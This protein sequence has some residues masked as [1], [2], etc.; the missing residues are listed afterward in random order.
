[1]TP[2]SSTDGNGRA[3]DEGILDPLTTLYT[4]PLL[5]AVL[6]KSVGRAS[7]YG[8]SLSLILFDLDHFAAIN[9]AYGRRVGDRILERLGILVRG[10]FR[11]YDWVARHGEDSIAV[12]LAPS[13]G[14]TAS[15][16]AQQVC[17]T[18][19]ER[20]TFVDHG[21]EQ[22]VRVTISAAVVNVRGGQR[23]PLEPARVM[24]DADAALAR[25]K[26][27][28]RNRVERVDP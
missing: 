20:L 26:Q 16:L 21:T 10:Y 3:V 8:E 22:T 4:R 11:Q 9:E 28:G 18:V 19:A 5:D 17:T 6:A 7:R 1:V 13:E 25:A 15:E 24:A 23:E 14:D 27:R 12:L 2:R